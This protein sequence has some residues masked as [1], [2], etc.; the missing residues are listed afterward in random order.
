MKVLVGPNHIGLENAIP[1]LQGKFPQLQFEKCS[2]RQKLADEIVDADVYF[3]WL[4]KGVFFAAEELKWIQSPSSG[5]NHY[6]AIS[7]LKDSDVLLTSA[8]GT[9]AACVA[10]SAL[11]MIFS[12]T[13]GIR[14]SILGQS[15]KNW[16]AREIRSQ[17]SE[18]TYS[19]IG[20]IGFGATGR[21]LAKRASA[22]DMRV[23]AVD[24]YPM[25]KPEYVEELWGIDQLHH[26]LRIS[27]YVVVMVPYTEQTNKMIG[28]HELEL[29][30]PSSMLV[31]MSRGG[32]IDQRALAD[33]LNKGWISAAALDVFDSEP[34][35]TDS[36]LWQL[37][38]L[39]ITPHVAGGTQHEAMYVIQIFEE[40]LSQFIKGNYDL[41]NLVD[42]QLGF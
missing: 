29:M 9:H 22:F 3:G 38:N 33:A 24:M 26:L 12:F 30:K 42:K 35:P 13:R 41:K 21:A 28:V 32:I 19:T 27:D 25:D 17:L 16:C 34:L 14:S 11:G 7:E 37:Q 31:G 1:D 39:L 20:V 15:E 2:D 10:E 36:E 5:I 6:L 18:L 40:N 4:D 8:S 23:V